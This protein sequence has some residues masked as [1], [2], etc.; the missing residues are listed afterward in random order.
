MADADEPLHR[1]LGLTDD[2]AEQIT[3]I[4]GRPPNHLEL[5]MFAVMWS[6]HC[7]Y[8]SSRLHL[9]RLPT[10]GPDVLV[11]PGENAGVMDVGDGVAVAL[12]IESHNHPSAVEP[13]QGAA[14]GV[15]GILRDIFTMG[16]RPIALMDPLFFG[17][18]DDARTR[19]LVEGV[20][21]GI[22]GYGNSVG[23][24][25]VGGELTFDPCYQ[26][27]PLVNVLCMGVL[28][29]ERLVLGQASGEGN[30]AI[31]LGSSTGR[32]GIGGVSV[33][34]SAGFAEAGE[35]DA[36]KR[37]SVQVG[38]P[39]EEKRLIEACLELL[40]RKLV[41][42]IQDLG[43]AGL[44]CATSE[45]AARAGMGMDVDVTAV[46]RREPG[47]EPFEVMTSESQERMLAIVA[48]ADRDAV[49]EVCRRWEVRASVV[50]VVTAP[51]AG[52]GGAST[53]R[54]RILDG[55]GGPVLADVPAASLSEDA[56]LYD[57]PLA[58]PADLSARRAE[59]L[60]DLPAPADCGEDVLAMLADPSWVYR[61]YDHQLFLNT[62]EGPGGDAAVLR[63]AAPGLP[64][65]RRGLALSTDANP[66][67]CAVDPRAGTAMTVAESALNVACA[68]ARPIAVVNCLNFGN[69][70]HPEVMWQLSEAIDGMTEACLALGLPVIGGNVSFYNESAGA[71]ID[72][73][74][75]I[76]VLGV[77][78]DLERRPPGAVFTSG[79]T[80][81]LLGDAGERSL[82]GSRWAVARRG[83]RAVGALPALDL[84]AQARLLE[85]VRTLVAE[86]GLLGGVHDVSGGG[87]GLALAEC[88]VRSG[89]GCVVSGVDGH[90]ALFTEAAGRVVASCPDPGAVLAAAHTAGVPAVVLG[91]AGGGRLV[92]GDLVDVVVE[93]AHLAWRA[94]LPKALGE[95]VAG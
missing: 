2:E 44:T 65:S 28:P 59:S 85:L 33:L 47:M 94:A 22:S 18:L 68:G 82:A 76:A 55:F 27:N 84:G 64:P 23:V 57:R 93:D 29:K 8:K 79:D 56:P 40:D 77:I 15:G 31:L 73:T 54:L 12:R 89:V 35:E 60:D 17:T 11:G 38:D 26:R 43:G 62:V 92:I 48:P 7:S 78:D 74:P 61:Q 52:P 51:A 72:P 86:P 6:E 87:L 88:A 69:P 39:F 16:A 41:V 32:D 3:S 49:E 91:E 24:P 95:P 36:A 5:A 66:R 42:G 63:L 19:W 25:T 81:V 14:T 67:W 50:G 37:P 83:R 90:A 71:D 4:L 30:L 1:A 80:V 10:E 34:A 53:G 21:A 58:P 9:R 75:T 70:E 46:V 45:T 20:V 13:Y